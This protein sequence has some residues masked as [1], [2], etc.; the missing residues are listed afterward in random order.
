MSPSCFCLFS[1]LP[2]GQW[3][4]NPSLTS[5]LN[6]HPSQPSGHSGLPWFPLLNSPCI[7]HQDI[8][9]WSI[10]LKRIMSTISSLIPCDFQFYNLITL[11]RD[12]MNRCEFLR[13]WKILKILN[14]NCLNL[15]NI[16][17][18]FICIYTHT[19]THIFTY[20]CTYMYVCMSIW[21][22]PSG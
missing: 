16:F 4:R 20:T 12:G 18:K 2:I 9:F 6:L 5:F 11:A 1:N 7:T 17:T 10:G 14:L 21:G 22:F 15:N 8:S 19:H 3:P 13:H